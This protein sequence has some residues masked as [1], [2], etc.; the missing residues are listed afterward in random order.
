MLTEEILDLI[1]NK[2]VYA[3]ISGITSAG[4]TLVLTH[5]KDIIGGYV[6]KDCIFTAGMVRTILFH[7]R[8]CTITLKS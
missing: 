7:E 2:N 5:S 4:S 8:G 1:C 6:Q 3:L